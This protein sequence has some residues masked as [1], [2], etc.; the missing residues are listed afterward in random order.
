[1]DKENYAKFLLSGMYE[2][3]YDE[4]MDTRD[5]EEKKDVYE[6]VE[7][8]K[9]AV[10]SVDIHSIAKEPVWKDDILGYGDRVLSCPMCNKPITN[11][12]SRAEYKPKFCH[13]CGQRLK[14]YTEE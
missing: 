9:L 4:Y 14:W 6:E 10:D 12:W 13:Y 1:M 5:P 2:D 7:A 8:L 3:K 11:V